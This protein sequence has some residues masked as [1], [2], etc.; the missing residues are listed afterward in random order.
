M[1]LQLTS[2]FPKTVHS[3]LQLSKDIQ[4]AMQINKN[5]QSI[6]QISNMNFYLTNS[7]VVKK[8]GNT[9]YNS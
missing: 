6:M 3:T 9:Y 5:I 7:T 1:F 8:R 2:P 4:S